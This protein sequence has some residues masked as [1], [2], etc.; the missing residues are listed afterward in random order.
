MFLRGERLIGPAR[1]RYLQELFDEILVR[2]C[3]HDV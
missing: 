1:A 3:D 2:L